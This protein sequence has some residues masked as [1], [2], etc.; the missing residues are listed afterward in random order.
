MVLTENVSPKLEDFVLKDKLDICIINGPVMNSGLQYQSL[1]S[2]NIVLVV[3]SN[4]DLAAEN[5]DF[6]KKEYINTSIDI[7]SLGEEKF[8]LLKENFRLGKISRQIF[9]HYNISPKNIIEVS[10]MNTA[11]SMSQVGLG[12]TFMPESGLNRMAGG[13]NN[14]LCFP[15]GEPSFSFPLVI[16]YKE[17][18]FNKQEIRCFIDFV[19]E[20]Y[21]P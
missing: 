5:Y 13:N 16:A 1:G 19:K 17:E 11:I 18:K 7:G 12:L 4:T 2:E 15:I 9:K 14:P 21:E 8:I 10:H 20:N 6:H 3:P